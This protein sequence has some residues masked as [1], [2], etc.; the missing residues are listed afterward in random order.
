MECIGAASNGY[1]AV[2]LATQINPDIILMDIEMEHQSAGIQAAKQIHE[3]L[4]HIKMI[5]LTVHK[6]DNIVFASFQSGIVDYLTK[7]ASPF[8]IT[9]A[10][11][12]AY[13]DVSPIRPIVADKIRNEFQR[14]KKTEQSLMYVLQIISDLT[15]SELQILSLLCE[16]KTRR[17]IAEI[18]SV[19]HDTIKKQISSLLKKFNAESTR[20]MVNGIND[21]K[22]FEII[23]K[24]K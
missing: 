10:V 2:S 17:E 1:E 5:M 8:E 21:L 13:N 15:K 24:I 20:Q 7:D 9:E 16:G 12:E 4:P 18:R 14:L 23:K 22:I 19:E 6:D 3:S 11:R